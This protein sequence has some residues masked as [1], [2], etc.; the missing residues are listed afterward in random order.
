LRMQI[1]YAFGRAVL[2]IETLDSVAL[3]TKL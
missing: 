2:E 1:P 3:L